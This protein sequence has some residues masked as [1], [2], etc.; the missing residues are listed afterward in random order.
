[1][2]DLNKEKLMKEFW[3]EVVY[4]TEAMKALE[5]VHETCKKIEETSQEKRGKLSYQAAKPM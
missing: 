1:M 5:Y 3:E 4:K 2:P